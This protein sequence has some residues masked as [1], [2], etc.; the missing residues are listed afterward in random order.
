MSSLRGSRWRQTAVGC[1][2]LVVSAHAG[3]AGQ[4]INQSEPRSDARPGWVFTPSFSFGGGWDDN[5]LLQG[6]VGPPLGDYVT[7]LIPAGA[8][9][10]NG[11]RLQLSSTYRGSFALYREL[12][13]L[14]TLDQYGR[15]GVRYRM[16]PRTTIGVLQSV[17]HAPTTDLVELVAVPFHRIGT[18]NSSTDAGVEVRLT[19]RTTART[20]YGFRLV[21]FDDEG[22]EQLRFPGGHAHDF[23]GA[24]D[25]RLSKRLTLG[26]LY[27]FQHARF[28]EVDSPVDVFD[29]SAPVLLHYAVATGEYRL[30]EVLTVLGSLGIDYL[31]EVDD[32][33]SRTGL[34]WK[35]A[36]VATWSRITASGSYD[37]SAVP[38]FGLGGV[39]DNEE[40]SGSIRGDFARRRVYWQ[41]DVALRDNE[42]ITPGIPIRRTVWLS[43]RTGYSI[44]PWLRI[45]G[46]YSFAA[47][48]NV[49]VLGGRINRNRV[50]FQIV[51]LKPLR[52]RT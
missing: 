12:T 16:T 8:L 23:V 51:T 36:V 3:V 2:L 10:Y 9:D 25:H 46:Y 20:G 11:Q 4:S 27:R 28:Q 37:K 33:P 30:S 38:S 48:D 7:S 52:L 21:D 19:A 24:V 26:G 22:V 13:D 49:Q 29:N 1:L 14:N 47:Q 18:L 44:Q 34:A 43:A 40:L 41:A 17:A 15:F 35:A 5:V 39:S 42:P 32:Q 6:N 31:A 45:E 50:G